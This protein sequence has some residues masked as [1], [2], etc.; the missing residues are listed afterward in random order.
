[1]LSGDLN[2][3]ARGQCWLIKG[4][5]ERRLHVRCE[6]FHMKVSLNRHERFTEKSANYGDY[7]VH[8]CCTV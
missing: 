8:S 4:T 3:L 7:I 6:L 2:D 5:N 1:M